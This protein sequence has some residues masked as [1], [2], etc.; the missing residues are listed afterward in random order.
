V[1]V[2]IFLKQRR[3]GDINNDKT[4]IKISDNGKERL[5]LI[6]VAILRKNVM[7]AFSNKEIK[8]FP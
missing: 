6:D 3:E 5:M 1:N 7:S 2:T 4:N 8:L